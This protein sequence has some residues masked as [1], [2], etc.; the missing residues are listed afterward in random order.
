MASCRTTTTTTA[1]PTSATAIDRAPALRT[2]SP[3]RPGRGFSGQRPRTTTGIPDTN[4]NRQPGARLPRG[5]PAVRRG[6]GRRMPTAGTANN[7]GVPDHREDDLEP[8]TTPTRSTRRAY[9]LFGTSPSAEPLA[10]RRADP[11]AVWQPRRRG[12]R[13]RRPQRERPTA[14]PAHPP[15][16]GFRCVAQVWTS[17]RASRSAS[18][19]TSSTTVHPPTARSLASPSA[20]AA[21]PSPAPTAPN[22]VVVTRS[23]WS[24]ATA[25]DRQHYVEADLHPRPRS[26]ACGGNLRYAVNEPAGR[27]PLSDGSDQVADDHHPAGR[28]VASS[29]E[30][31]REPGRTSWQVIGPGQGAA[32]A[33]GPGRA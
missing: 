30:Y 3:L 11:R 22:R 31:V 10:F 15:G 13:R 20:A 8:R 32:A 21:S 26:D 12:H 19:T 5:V 25:L 16:T 33:R 17:R 27:R 6:A 4:R 23:S 9:H 24:T 14:W 1:I 29:A 18:M 2:T 28:S 7:N